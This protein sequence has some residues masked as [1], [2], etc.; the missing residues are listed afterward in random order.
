MVQ[1]QGVYSD[2]LTEPYGELDSLEEDLAEALN[3]S[4]VVEGLRV[5]GVRVLGLRV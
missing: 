2:I 3:A 1:R 4:L 5:L